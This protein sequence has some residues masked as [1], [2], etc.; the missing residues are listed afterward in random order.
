M[1]GLAEQ[2]IAFIREVSEIEDEQTLSALIA[3]YLDYGKGKSRRQTESHSQKIR[4]GRP[5]A[6]IA[7]ELGTIKTKS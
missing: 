4:C 7:A 3:A 6:T 1:N 2:K 5:S